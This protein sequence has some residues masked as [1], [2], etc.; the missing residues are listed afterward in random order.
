M[1]FTA[2]G[3]AL[4]CAGLGGCY[5]EGGPWGSED[6]YAYVSREW[7]PKTVTLRDTRTGQDF[8]S[9]DVPVGK[10][11]L[12][13]FDDDAGAENQYTPSKMTWGL[14][15]PDFDFGDPE[16]KNTLDVPPPSGRR[17]DVVIRTLPEFAPSMVAATKG[18]VSPV[19]PPTVREPS[20]RVPPRPASEVD[21]PPSGATP[22]PSRP[23]PVEPLNQP[24]MVVPPAPPAPPAAPTPPTPPTPPA[25]PATPTATPPAA[26]PAID[27]PDTS[28]PRP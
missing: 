28:A 27:L 24:G 15:E 21:L 3:L 12:I 20:L 17:L 25:P 26:E 2:A 7:E 19:R 23:T 4:A 5:A 6:S 18:A 14:V 13:E 9:I 11:L 10:K 22:A 16:L 1:V 8:W